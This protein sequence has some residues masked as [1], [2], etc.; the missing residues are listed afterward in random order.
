[1]PSYPHVLCQ[2]PGEQTRATPARDR[3]AARHHLGRSPAARRT[4][5]TPAGTECPAQSPRRQTACPHSPAGARARRCKANASA[6]RRARPPTLPSMGVL[7]RDRTWFFTRW[8]QVIWML[9]HL[10]ACTYD[11]GPVW[12]LLH[13]VLEQESLPERLCRTH[14]P[15]LGHTDTGSV[16]RHLRAR[17][18]CHLNSTF[19]TPAY[20]GR[21]GLHH[22]VALAVRTAPRQHTRQNLTLRPQQAT[23]PNAAGA[24]AR[25]AKYKR[26][27]RAGK[28]HAA[29]ATPPLHACTLLE[30]I[31]LGSI[32]PHTGSQDVK[33]DG[34]GSHAPTGVLTRCECG[35]L[36]QQQ[37]LFS[38][39]IQSCNRE[40]R[41]KHE[42]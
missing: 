13:A 42:A 19:D 25:R 6:P 29:R 15:S 12:L 9:R 22:H 39:K 21:P 2:H 24:D 1:M 40:A 35:T 31:Q 26:G 38:K 20:G 41:L 16:R 28:A 32:S 18:P 4:P 3:P 17:A 10:C 7:W 37:L 36:P 30:Q 23:A 8:E 34:R 33:P 27:A 11:Q 5:A 14:S